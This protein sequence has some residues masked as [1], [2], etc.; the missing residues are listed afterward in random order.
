MM[1]NRSHRE[2]VRKLWNKCR[3]RALSLYDKGMSELQVSRQTGLPRKLLH[4]RLVSEGRSIRG[5]SYYSLGERNPSWNGGRKIDKNGY[6]QLY[7]PNHPYRDKHNCVREHR[8]VM[9]QKLGRY[10]LPDE[11]VDHINGVKDDNRPENLRL[12]SSNAEHLASTLKGR[13]PQWSEEGWDKI[14]NEVLPRAR[15]NSPIHRHCRP[16]RGALR[17]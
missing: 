14:V 3:R 11:V 12:F 15:E 5:R 8:L 6:V 17:S 1:N 16:R 9:E 7:C 10:L 13:R 4:L 2:E